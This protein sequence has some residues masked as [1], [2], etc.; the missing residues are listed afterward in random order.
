MEKVCPGCGVSLSLN[1]ETCPNCKQEFQVEKKVN[2][3]SI[4]RIIAG[5]SL[6]INSFILIYEEIFM[7]SAKISHR[8][9]KTIIFSI[10]LGIMI[11]TGK[12]KWLTWAQISIAIGAVIYTIMNI[13]SMEYFLA[14]VQIV[15]SLSLF[16]LV[17]S[18]PAKK[19]TIVCIAGL[20]VYFLISF[21]GV[22]TDITGKNVLNKYYKLLSGDITTPESTKVKGHKYNYLLMMPNNEWFIRNHDVVVKEN[23]SAD[24]WLINPIC[25]SHVLIICESLEGNKMSLNDYSKLV[26]SNLNKALKDYKIIHS[27]SIVVQNNLKG[28]FYDITG[29]ID[30][31]TIRYNYGLFVNN[32]WAFQIVCFSETKMYDTVKKDFNFIINSFTLNK[33]INEE[34]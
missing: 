18:N 8:S 19:R 28:M 17:Y 22:Y 27:N 24:N 26:M 15:F 7:E 29:N 34:I 30:N 13:T 23:G 14:A 2:W 21:F 6:I 4:A 11:L 20:F 5:I 9:E 10:A 1:T 16:G 32:G 3:P 12:K 33:E 31:L 25:D